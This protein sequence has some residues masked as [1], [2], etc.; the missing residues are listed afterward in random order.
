MQ[1]DR[2]IDLNGAVRNNTKKKKKTS[3]LK[4][5]KVVFLA[6]IDV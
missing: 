5:P 2:V 4:G 3:T 1:K 6:A